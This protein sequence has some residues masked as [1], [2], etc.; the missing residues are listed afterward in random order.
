M[1]RIYGNFSRE[2]SVPGIVDPTQI[3]ASLRNGVLKIVAPKLER[4]QAILVESRKAGR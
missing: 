1:E 3:K 4:R 2:F